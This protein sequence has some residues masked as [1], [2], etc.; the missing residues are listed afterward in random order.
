MKCFCNKFTLYLTIDMIDTPCKKNDFPFLLVT[1]FTTQICPT[2]LSIVF[3]QPRLRHEIRK[4]SVLQNSKNPKE[5]PHWLTHPDRTDSYSSSI[6]CLPLHAPLLHSW[7]IL[8]TSLI[9][10]NLH[11]HVVIHNSGLFCDKNS[12]KTYSSQTWTHN[13]DSVIHMEVQQN[14]KLVNEFV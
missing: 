10:C 5:K 8:S 12:S 14:E 1:L 13:C 9:F 3:H 2:S 11:F 7:F 6:A 4:A